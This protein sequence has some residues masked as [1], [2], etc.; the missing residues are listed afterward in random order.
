M[1][2]STQ[3]QHVCWWCI[4]DYRLIKVGD[5]YI[6]LYASTCMTK[7]GNTRAKSS[8]CGKLLKLKILSLYEN[9]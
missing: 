6:K 9:V 3:S 7:S 4:Q 5:A 1:P 8:N 2:L